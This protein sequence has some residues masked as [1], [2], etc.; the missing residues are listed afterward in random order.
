MKEETIYMIMYPNSTVGQPVLFCGEEDREAFAEHFELEP[1]KSRVTGSHQH[2]NHQFHE[3][4]KECDEVRKIVIKH[5]FEGWEVKTD[6]RVELFQ[7]KTFYVPQLVKFDDFDSI[8]EF[9][10]L[11]RE[12]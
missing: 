3:Y 10:E 12:L 6:L 4:L 8:Q 9:K 5:P 11:A 7:E 2:E 1:F